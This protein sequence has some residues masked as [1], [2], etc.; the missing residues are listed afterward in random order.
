M[1]LIRKV[2][3]AV[4][5]FCYHSSA[6]GVTRELTQQR[7]ELDTVFMVLILGDGCACFSILLLASAVALFTAANGF[8]ETNS[9]TSHRVGKLVN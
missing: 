5:D 8:V 7:A 9:D 1:F 6:Y 4:I 3:Q 2:G